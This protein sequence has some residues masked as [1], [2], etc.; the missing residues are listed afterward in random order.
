MTTLKTALEDI[1]LLKEKLAE[2]DQRLRDKEEQITSRDERI[3]DLKAQVAWL[4]KML[5][6]PGKSEKMDRAQLLLQLGDVTTAID[7]ELSRETVKVQYERPVGR[8]RPLPA[9]TFQ[10]LPVKET[11]ELIPEE[12]RKDPSLYV[13]INQEETFEVV[14]VPGQLFKRVFIRP[15]FVHRIDRSRPPV[16]SPALPRV[17]E[18]GYASAE[19]VSWV[20]AS[21]YLDHL[22][23]YRL[24]KMTERWGA[25]LPRQSMSDWVGI[26][27]EW[28]RPLYERMR[29]DLKAGSYLQADETPVSFLNP[30]AGKGKARQ[31]YLWVM[32]R[33][34][35]PVLFDWK[36][37]RSQQSA[38]DLLGGFKGALQTDGYQAYESLRQRDPEGLVRVGCL[39]HLRRKFFE[40]LA[41]SPGEAQRVL[42]IIAEIY[43]KEKLYREEGLDPPER[44]DR[45]Q[46]ELVPV[47]TRLHQTISELQSPVRPSQPLGKACG[48]ALRQW[49]SIE[50]ILKFG[51]VEVDNNLIENAIRPSAVGKKNWLFIGSPEAGARPAIIYSLVATCQRFGLNPETWL[52]ETLRKLPAMTNQDDLSVLLPYHNQWKPS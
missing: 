52:S 39:A 6:G 17:I 32:G 33:P 25:R 37:D 28:L 24:E 46:T 49:P 47:F 15:R 1:A 31:G 16:L 3:A 10:N 8:S 13:K 21:K 51:E 20:L 29:T 11:I 14:A 5:Y 40:S 38:A 7:R 26:A 27:T 35:G 19:L 30:E 45:R 18:G 50:A 44:K 41:T 42:D 43:Q 22:P 9:E 48:Y 23:L 36:T 12:V 4:K 2:R 34:G